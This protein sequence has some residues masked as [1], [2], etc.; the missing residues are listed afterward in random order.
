V[1]AEDLERQEVL[2]RVMGPAAWGVAVEELA[3]ALLA[4]AGA[5]PKENSPVVFVERKA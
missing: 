1:L 4:R 5:K 2:E 3:Y